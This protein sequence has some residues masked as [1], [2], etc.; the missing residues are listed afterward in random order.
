MTVESKF[1]M[2]N[3]EA[4]MSAVTFERVNEGLCVLRLD[5]GRT[6]LDFSEDIAGEPWCNKRP[7]LGPA[8]APGVIPAPSAPS[9]PGQRGRG[10]TARLTAR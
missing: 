6:G 2:N 9:A 1:S 5:R 10:R 8:F 4:T 7:G 3:A